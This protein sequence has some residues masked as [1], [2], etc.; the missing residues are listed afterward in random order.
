MKLYEF[1][2]QS[3][4]TGKINTMTLPIAPVQFQAWVEHKN[5]RFI[6]DAFPQLTPDQREFLLTGYTPEDWDAIFGE[7]E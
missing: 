3:P 7:E 5:P 6:Q 1:E 2:R 4:L